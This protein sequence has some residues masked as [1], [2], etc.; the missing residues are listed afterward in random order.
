MALM[1]PQLEHLR[2]KDK[3][4]WEALDRIV[5]HINGL[6]V[7]VTPSTPT[8]A[9]P[10][11]ATQVVRLSSGATLG[12]IPDDAASD[13]Y[14][15]TL[16]QK[17]ALDQIAGD[18]SPNSVYAGPAVASAGPRSMRLLVAADIPALDA[19]KIV[20]GILDVLRVPDLDA[21]KITSGAFPSARIGVHDEP[22]V[23]PRD[24]LT[25]GGSAVTALTEEVV[26]REAELVFAGTDVISVTGMPN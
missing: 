20:S 5:K 19:A 3:L 4:T 2:N 11:S 22:L 24:V 15:V 10:K 14:A 12:D 23:T 17:T 7:P 13:R 6:S 21:T 16:L 26:V 25:A 18:A 1:V 9:Q 8:P